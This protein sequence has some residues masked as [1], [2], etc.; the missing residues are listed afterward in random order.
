MYKWTASLSRNWVNDRPMYEY[1]HIEW[2][3]VLICAQTTSL[4]DKQLILV[5]YLSTDSEEP[6][7]WQE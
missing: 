1:W 4:R 3:G 7:K 6:G 5:R 2:T